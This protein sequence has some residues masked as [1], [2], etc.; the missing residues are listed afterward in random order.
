[1]DFGC[2]C[3]RVRVGPS[4]PVVG[5][6][7]AVAWPLEYWR[8]TVLPR[9]RRLRNSADFTTTV[10]RGRRCSTRLLTVHAV[11][12]DSSAPA[13]AGVVVSKAV[14]V[15]VVRNRVKRRLRAGLHDLSHGL[16]GG[17][18]VVRALP[19]AATADFHQLSGDLKDCLNRLGTRRG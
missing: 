6:R 3:G 18:I 13:R 2:G 15:A 17:R 11:F 10:A 14:G 16:P 5:A 1:M 12:D 7:A 4:S 19:P 9:N 8:T